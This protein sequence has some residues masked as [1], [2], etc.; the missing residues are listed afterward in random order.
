MIPTLD[1]TLSAL[2]NEDWDESFEFYRNTEHCPDDF[3]VGTV[4]EIALLK[5]VTG[6]V[7][8]RLRSDDAPTPRAYINGHIIVAHWPA[9]QVQAAGAGTYDFQIREFAPGG[10][11]DTRLVGVVQFGAGL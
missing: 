5:R 7:V 8:V 6:A 2:A 11:Q 10:D 1:E 9:A 3:P 4:V